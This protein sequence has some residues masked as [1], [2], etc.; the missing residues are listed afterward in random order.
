MVKQNIQGFCGNNKDS[1]HLED[2]VVDGRKKLK[3]GVF[4]EYSGGEWTG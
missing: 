3:K 1:T 2:L 4:K